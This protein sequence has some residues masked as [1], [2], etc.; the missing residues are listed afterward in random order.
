MLKAKQGKEIVVRMAD[1]IGVLNELSKILAEKGLNI[2]AMSCWVEGDE[3]VIRLVTDDMLRTGD[4]I[5]EHG[6]TMKEGDVV[7]VDAQHKPGILRHVAD[8]LA[9]HKINLSHLYASATLSQDVCLVVLNS[10]NNE[11]AMVLL[12]D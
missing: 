11:Q 9:R 3:A 12:N 2:L 1:D 5:R 10:T 8:T 4:A 6:Y 7:L